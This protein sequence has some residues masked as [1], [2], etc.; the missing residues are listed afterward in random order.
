M[1]AI[2]YKHVAYH[3]LVAL[4]FVWFVVFAGLLAMA[5]VHYLNNGNYDLSRALVLWILFNL[6]MGTVLFIVIRLF[7]KSHVTGRIIL[8][9]YFLMAASSVTVMLIMANP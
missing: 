5:L 1:K 4:Y 3:V 8:Y 7:R 6:V 9:T 2:D